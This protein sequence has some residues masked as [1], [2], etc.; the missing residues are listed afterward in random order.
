MNLLPRLGK[1]GIFGIPMCL[2]CCIFWGYEY[3]QILDVLTPKWPK[4]GAFAEVLDSSGPHMTHIVYDL[5]RYLYVH[6]LSLGSS[7]IC[8]RLSFMKVL[9]L[10]PSQTF[11]A[12]IAYLEAFGKRHPLGL[13][14]WWC[15]TP[16]IA[17]KSQRHW[18]THPWNVL[19]CAYLYIRRVPLTISYIFHRDGVWVKQDPGTKPGRKEN[20][21][22][23]I[24]GVSI[25]QSQVAFRNE[26]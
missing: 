20:E 18:T 7:F 23:P 19:A 13:I 2:N 15:F 6:L 21:K 16:F 3:V 11:S 5:Y 12:C 22:K 4:T 14:I 1:K 26:T 25:F 17:Q 10:F 9:T 8:S 24:K